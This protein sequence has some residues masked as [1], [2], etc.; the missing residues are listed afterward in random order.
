VNANFVFIVATNLLSVQGSLASTG[1]FIG[2]PACPASPAPSTWVPAVSPTSCTSPGAAS[3]S[4]F[5]MWLQGGSITLQK[6][7]NVE[8]PAI[9]V[10]ARTLVVQDGA[11]LSA[12]GVGCGSQTGFGAGLSL[13]GQPSSG[14]GH[15]GVGGMGSDG[16]GDTLVGGLAYDNVTG[17]CA[18]V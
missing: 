18:W 1:T 11:Q 17:A 13:V 8:A 2:T 7:S 16:Q 5:S 14:A 10:C 15:G 9:R 3:A 12:S 6:S 4:G